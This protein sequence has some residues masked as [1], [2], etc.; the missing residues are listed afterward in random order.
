MYETI[1]VAT[2]GSEP[3]DRAISQAIAQAK[4]T[5]ATLHAIFVVD[6]HRYTEPALSSAEL[7]TTLIEDWG[8]DHLATVMDRAED[9]GVDAMT[10]CRHGLPFE[11]I[12]AYGE[13]VEADLIVLGHQGHSHIR[14]DQLGRVTARVLGESNRPVLVVQ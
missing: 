7:D 14:S 5:D 6:T 2:D 12:I 3:A 1:V 8:T 9:H 13:D 10:T 4:R 11:E